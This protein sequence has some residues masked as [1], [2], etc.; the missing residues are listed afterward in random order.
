MIVSLLFLILVFAIAYRQATFGLFSAMIMALLTICC[1]ALAIGL[2]EWVAIN[3]IAPYWKPSMSF[4]IALGAL[5]GIPLILLR[6]LF[7]KMVS[8]ACLIPVWIDRIGGGAFGFLTGMTTT[9]ILALCLQMLPMGRTIL[10]YERMK[11]YARAGANDP[12]P[13]FEPGQDEPLP[14]M[15]ETE[16]EL[17]L[18]PDRFATAAASFLSAG[19][20]ADKQPFYRDNPDFPSWVGQ[21]GFVPAQVSRFA[22]PDS[23]EVV[24]TD[25]VEFVYRLFPADDRQGQAKRFEPIEPKPGHDFRVVRL[26][27]K[28]PARDEQKS[29]VFTLRQFRLVGTAG[30]ELLQLA[31]VAIQQEDTAEAINRHIRVVRDANKD[32]PLTDDLLQPRQNRDPR[33]ANVVEIVFSV[34]KGF[35]PNFLEYKRGARVALKFSEGDGGVRE[36][37]TR[38]A[39]SGSPSSAEAPPSG[40]QPAPAAAP[41]EGGPS[42]EASADAT[43][44]GGRR[45][46]RARRVEARS[47]GSFFGE[48]MPMT[49]TKYRRSPDASVAQSKLESGKLVAVVSE[50]A[51]GNDPPINAFVVPSNKR[52]LHL[53]SG[54]LQAG[55][56]F[57]GALSL[58]IGTMQNYTVTAENGGTY[59]VCGKYAIATH[60]GTEYLEVQ[61]YP[62]AMGAT[63]SLGRFDEIKDD[64]IKEDD[65]FVLLF[66]V[67]PGVKIK[68]FSTGSKVLQGDELGGEL[69]APN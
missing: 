39:E 67:D 13:G 8:R 30:G 37:G 1:A 66:L 57:G 20:L 15:I 42:G 51:G 48:Q 4:A 59:R 21:M 3:F 27:L 19:L 14:G 54:M 61:Y 24:S 49:L 38:P 23:I 62:E 40:A 12:P 50:Q 16:N 35:Q 52:L 10:G 46:G 41:P 55:S 26:R 32:R 43:R 7:D 17:L 2:H 11:S 53:S 9:G 58:A 33:D 45:G 25:R 18:S 22:P 65:T 44:E 68:S 56:G 60:A 69:I 31:P 64:E 5:F 34:P 6:L 36:A 29:H 47:S 28:D 63:G